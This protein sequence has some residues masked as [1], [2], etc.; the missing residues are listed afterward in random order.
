MSEY[1]LNIATGTL[2]L[3]LIFG[4]M[5]PVEHEDEYIITHSEAVVLCEALDMTYSFEAEGNT[6]DDFCRQP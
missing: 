6:V 2:A 1:V 3:I 5:S 4:V